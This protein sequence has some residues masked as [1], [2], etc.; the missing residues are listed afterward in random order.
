MLAR[1]HLFLLLATLVAAPV[2]GQVQPSAT[3]GNAT[4]EDDTQMITPPP[5]NG[6]PYPTEGTGARTN[7]FKGSLA[8]EV[9]YIDNVLPGS[10]TIPVSDTTY[11]VLSDISLQKTTPRQSAT[12]RYSPSFIFYEP[13]TQLNAV[14]HSA[15]IIYQDRIS[16]HLSITLD[17]FFL[18]TSNVFSD[19]YPFTA[20]GLTGSPQAPVPAIIA[21]FTEQM[22]D[23]ANGAINYQFSRDSMIGGGGSYSNFDLPNTTQATGLS[24]STGEGATAFYSRRL[25]RA[26]YAGVSYSYSRTVAGSFPAQDINAQTHTLL[27][28]YTVYFNRTFSL[29]V[30]GG[31][32]RTTESQAQGTPFISWSPSGVASVG[33][34]GNRGN[35]AI[36]Y[37]YAITSGQG[38]YGA[39]RSAGTNAAGGL[40]VSRA[41]NASFSFSYTTTSAITSLINLSYTG[42]KAL[43]AQA[44]LSRAFGEHFNATFGYQRLQE[45]YN[46]VPVVSDNPD[47][48]RVFGRI[49]YQFSKA[50]GR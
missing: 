33:W 6:V 48:D 40:K 46:G 42:G 10:T 43:T 5:V 35:L 31:V 50:L 18:R 25:A 37:L 45:T 16:P 23:N 12:L 19:S 24:L 2:L 4:T 26:Q 32:Q 9:A 13:T 15:S 11:T 27:P 21:P 7:Y 30:T 34:Q 1:I 14:D 47:S 36:S 3:G 38:L 49:T 41:W 20:G 22:N 39:F 44:A 29:S 8:A 17:D 28:F